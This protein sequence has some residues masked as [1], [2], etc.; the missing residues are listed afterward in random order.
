MRSDKNIKTP[1]NSLLDVR[2]VNK[3]A[4]VEQELQ[5]IGQGSFEFCVM[6]SVTFENTYQK[7]LVL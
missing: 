3:I 4:L 7:L 5:I 1:H 2:K 6:T